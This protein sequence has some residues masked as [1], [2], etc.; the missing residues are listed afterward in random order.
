MKVVYAATAEQ[1][2]EI[3]KLLY[4]LRHEILPFY[5][6]ETVLK[7]QDEMGLLILQE[8]NHLYNGTMSEAFR[9]MAALQIISLI[10]TESHSG[11]LQSSINQR[12]RFEENKKILAYYGLFFPFEYE[13]FVD[14][15]L[16]TSMFA[17]YSAG[18][19]ILIV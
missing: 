14:S 7:Q 9:V 10:I 19:D 16:N 1:E 13:S 12:S 15:P 11:T 18:D 3:E 2:S 17:G 6:D 5:F 4:C 8:Q